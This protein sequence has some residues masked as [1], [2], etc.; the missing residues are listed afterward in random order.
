MSNFNQ[1]SANNLTA[2]CQDFIIKYTHQLIWRQVDPPNKNCHEC[3]KPTDFPLLCPLPTPAKNPQKN[4]EL[5]RKRFYEMR[6]YFASNLVRPV[7][8]A[9]A[10]ACHK[11][12]SQNRLKYGDVILSLVFQDSFSH[13][14]E[15]KAKHLVFRK[16]AFI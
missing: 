13:A 1:K 3:F 4:P 15:I 8:E 7:Y 2:I 5:F 9:L 11:F 16:W 14:L 6:Y 10:L 12:V